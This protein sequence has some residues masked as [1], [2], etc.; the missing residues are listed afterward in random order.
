MIFLKREAGAWKLISAGTAFMEEDFETLKIPTALRTPAT[1]LDEQ[2]TLTQAGASYIRGFVDETGETFFVTPS[3]SEG[4]FARLLVLP[5][6]DNTP[7][8]LYMKREGGSW[9][10]LVVGAP[11][12]AE[13]YEQFKIPQGLR[14]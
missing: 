4:D 12:T 7:G 8:F 3:A 9:Q 10:G 6:F 11:P 13:E 2:I 5:E 14:V 1:D